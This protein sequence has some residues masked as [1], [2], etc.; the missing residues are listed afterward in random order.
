[1]ILLFNSCNSWDWKANPYEP[2]HEYGSVM[3]AEGEEVFFDDPA[4]NDF[5]CFPSDNMAELIYNIK[6]LRTNNKKSRKQK[7]SLINQ[8]TR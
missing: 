4:I 3:N 5:T 6:K 1:M 7:S 2:D 8:L